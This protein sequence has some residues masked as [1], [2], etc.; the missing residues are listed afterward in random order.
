MCELGKKDL[1]VDRGIHMS[2]HRAVALR[3]GA[4]VE[5]YP[6]C[7]VRSPMPL[8]RKQSI[9]CT[10]SPVVPYWWKKHEGLTPSELWPSLIHAIEAELYRMGDMVNDSGMPKSCCV[11]RSK[12]TSIVRRYALPRRASAELGRI[13]MVRHVLK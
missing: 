3:L 1:Q 9:G 8:P 7:S 5:N 10:R 12:E 6:I 2:P 4:K 11:G 13:D